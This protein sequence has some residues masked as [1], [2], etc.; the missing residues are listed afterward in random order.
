MTLRI[1]LMLVVVAITCGAQNVAVPVEAEPHHK[2][3]LKNAYVQVFRVDLAPGESTQMHTHAHDDAAVRFSNAT[4]AANKSGEPLGAPEPVSPGQVSARDNAAK[5]YT[6]RVHNI[7]STVFDVMDVQI[8]SRPRGPASE[9]ID[10]PAAENASM[11]VYRY[12]LA[13]G[14]SSSKHTHKR[15]YL[16]VAATDMSLRM[17]SPDSQSMELPLKTGDLHWVETTV[18]HTLTN[19][20]NDKA[21]L[22]EFEL[23]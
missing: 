5:P 22:V 21:I 6:H 11:R 3:V 17:S 15:P 12:E 23:K 8:L 4:V 10:K 18:T 16:I 2:T 14:E 7:G 1:V 19:S 9:P 20:G 13:P